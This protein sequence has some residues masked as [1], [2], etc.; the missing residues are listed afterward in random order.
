MG[1]ASP[2]LFSFLFIRSALKGR[3]GLRAE[4]EVNEN[5]RERPGH[6][7]PPWRPF[8]ASKKK[9]QNESRLSSVN[10]GV[11]LGCYVPAF[12]AERHRAA[13]AANNVN[14]DRNHDTSV[15]GRG[16]RKSR[17]ASAERGARSERTKKS[18]ELGTRNEKALPSLSHTRHICVHLRHPWPAIAYGD[19]GPGPP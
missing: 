2:L 3:N 11:A 10:Q 12:Q 13:S 15:G 4:N 16:Q 7:H 19:G 18:V 17:K 9:K 8:R 6:S 5:P 1:S 14:H